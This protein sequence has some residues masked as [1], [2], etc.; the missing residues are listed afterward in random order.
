MLSWK[1]KW[2]MVYLVYLFSLWELKHIN[3]TLI[4]P[5]TTIKGQSPACIKYPLPFE[6]SQKEADSHFLCKS[7]YYSW[8]F[9]QYQSPAKFSPISLL[10]TCPKVSMAHFCSGPAL[11]RPQASHEG[12]LY[13]L[14]HLSSPKYPQQGRHS[15]SQLV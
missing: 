10:S 6:E 1:D 8:E 7:L 3:Y 5:S 15:G 14:F 4:I 11:I 13:F 2:L 9:S 12:W